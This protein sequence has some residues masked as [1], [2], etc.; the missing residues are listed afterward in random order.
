MPYLRIIPMHITI[1]GASILEDKLNISLEHT[2]VVVLFL[3]LK[4]IADVSMYINIRQGMTYTG[5]LKSSTSC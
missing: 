3:V 5:K 2:L 4:T 1:I